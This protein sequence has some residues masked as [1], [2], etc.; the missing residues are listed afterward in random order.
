MVGI[1][2]VCTVNGVDSTAVV[3]NTLVVVGVVVCA[4]E[5]GMYLQ[6]DILIS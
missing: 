4:S 2:V 6:Q 5:H 3:V 1:I